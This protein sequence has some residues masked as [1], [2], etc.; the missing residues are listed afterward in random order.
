[1][2]ICVMLRS[3]R[4]GIVLPS[5]A[6]FVCFFFF[7]LGRGNRNLTEIVTQASDEKNAFHYLLYCDHI[8]YRCEGF[9]ILQLADKKF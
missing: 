8:L 5:S 6:V 4:S 1:M 2:E 3:C 9:S 7:W